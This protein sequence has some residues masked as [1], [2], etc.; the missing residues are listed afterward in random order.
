VLIGHSLWA[1]YLLN[2][3]DRDKKEPV[4]KTIFVSGF[5]GK[6]NNKNFDTLNWDFIE[7]DFDWERIRES[8]GSVIIFHWDNDP[9]IPI[10]EAKNLHKHLWWE[11]RIVEWGGHFN[12]EARYIE[13]EELLNQI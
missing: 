7:K 11:I 10:S 9:Y 6:L 1:T 2:I 5:T 12:K 8:A 4:E 13:F 3:L